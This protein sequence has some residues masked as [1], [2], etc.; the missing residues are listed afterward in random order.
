MI[1]WLLEKYEDWKFERDFQRKKKELIKIDPFIYDLP[2]K[3]TNKDDN[4]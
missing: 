4:L 3:D 2:K 1:K